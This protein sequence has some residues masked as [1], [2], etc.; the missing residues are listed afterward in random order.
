MK[1]S[2][3]LAESRGQFLYQCRPDLF[4][5]GYLTIAEIELWGLHYEQRERKREARKSKR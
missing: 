3:A 5:E 4:P 2:L 1:A